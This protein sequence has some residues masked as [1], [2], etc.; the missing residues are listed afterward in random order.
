MTQKAEISYLGELANTI[1]DGLTLTFESG[2]RV[3]EILSRIIVVRV[4]YFL[5]ELE[6]LPKKVFG[7]GLIR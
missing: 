4:V 3:E 2:R 6:T 7:P 1:P 5:A